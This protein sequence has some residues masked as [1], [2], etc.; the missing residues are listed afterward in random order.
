VDLSLLNIGTNKNNR[1]IG[2]LS[3][4]RD[5]EY[6]LAGYVEELDRFLNKVS[7]GNV[8]VDDLEITSGT[9]ASSSNFISGL[10]ENI[11]D[12][13][14][15][16]DAVSKYYDYKQ[17]IYDVLAYKKE[18]GTIPRYQIQMDVGGNENK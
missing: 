1:F 7:N 17:M 15:H 3:N 12:L 11:A 9:G 13:V 6:R 14:N 18:N 4:D 16:A 5:E 8:T 10:P 2:S